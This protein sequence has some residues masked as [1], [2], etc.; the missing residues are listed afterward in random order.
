[1]DE[2]GLGVIGIYYLVS[3]AQLRDGEIYRVRLRLETVNLIRLLLDRN[4]GESGLTA[5]TIDR[6]YRY[7]RNV[8]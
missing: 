2:A 6:R 7:V 1:V 8:Y 4:Q 3:S 5:A